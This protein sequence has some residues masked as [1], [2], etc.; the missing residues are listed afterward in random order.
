M[1]RTL[2]TRRPSGAK[3]RGPLG[4][5]V[6]NA[7]EFVRLSTAYLPLTRVESGIAQR[8]LFDSNSGILYLM[9]P[10]KRSEQRS[11]RQEVL[12]RLP[13]QERKRARSAGER[14][15]RAAPDLRPPRGR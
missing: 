15:T 7:A 5:R 8:A 2:P 9:D 4:V 1:K 13:S 12:W 3:H 6:V 11:R 14:T 10:P